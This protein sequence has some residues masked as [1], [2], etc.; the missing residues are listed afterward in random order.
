MA[1]S[2]TPPLIHPS[3]TPHTPRDGSENPEPPPPKTNRGKQQT[4]IAE[5][6]IRLPEATQIVLD[7]LHAA[8]YPNA[9]PDDAAAV[10]RAVCQRYPG[11]VN[12]RYLRTMA[13]N[14]SYAPFYEDVRTARG[15]QVEAAIRD[16]QRTEP[17]CEH[18]TPAGRT[19]HPTTGLL[20]CALCRQ[21]LPARPE[22]RETTHPVVLAALNAYRDHTSGPLNALTLM[23]ITQEA[24]ALHNRHVPAEIVAHLAAKAAQSNTGLLAAATAQRRDRS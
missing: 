9:T 6:A 1:L 11:K 24:T 18:D 16:L 13:S 22:P 23:R 12:L 4:L 20:L 15:E 8:G 7:G 5:S 2:A 14:R 3:I 19:L 21:G 10:H 17:A